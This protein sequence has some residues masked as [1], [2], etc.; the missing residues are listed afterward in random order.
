[1]ELRN[2]GPLVYHVTL[3]SHPAIIPSS[4]AVDWCII[5]DDT[6]HQ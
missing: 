3:I 1:M 4:W 2:L 5:K 6:R